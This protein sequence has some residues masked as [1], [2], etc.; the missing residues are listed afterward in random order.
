ML[1]RAFTQ[2][3]PLPLPLRGSARWF[4]PTS[5]DA[6]RIHAWSSSPAAPDSIGVRFGSCSLDFALSTC[7]TAR[8]V[9]PLV[10]SWRIG[11][12]LPQVATGRFTHLILAT[13]PFVI[14]AG[15]LFRLA[16]RP[17]A[18]RTNALP[19]EVV[20]LFLQLA[21]T[22]QSVGCPGPCKGRKC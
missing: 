20:A 1:E 6:I 7:G 10:R 13:T 3:I 5:G 9:A 22:G 21:R 19:N 17:W 2:R 11:E 15:A 12:D 14:A 18:T 16:T 8:T 4:Q